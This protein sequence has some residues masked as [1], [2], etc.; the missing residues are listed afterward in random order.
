MRSDAP[1]A[2]AAPAG[3]E[4]LVQRLARAEA[5]IESLCREIVERYE[6][7]TLIHRLSDQL[8]ATLGEQARAQLVVEEASRALG[9][10][11]AE[12]WLMHDGELRLAASA[13]EPSPVAPAGVLREEGPLGALRHGRPWIREAGLGSEAAVAVPLGTPRAEAIGVLVLRGREDGRAFGTSEVKLLSAVT[14]LTAAFLRNDRLAEQARLTEDRRRHVALAREVHQTLRASREVDFPGLDV[15][16]GGGAPDTLGGDYY[17]HVLSP[18]GSL[19]LAL[20]SIAGDGVGAALCMAAAKGALE[21]EARAVGSPAEILRRTNETLAAEFTRTDAF[22][23]AFVARLAP[24][25]RALAYANGGHP[26]PLL[27]RA[28]GAVEELAEGGPVLGVFE[29]AAFLDDRVT[30]APGDIVALFT[31]ELRELASP[32]GQRFG[33]EGVLEALRSRP[34][35][36]ARELYEAVLAGAR[37]CRGA[38]ERPAHDPALVIVRAVAKT[39]AERA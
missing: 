13:P 36:S 31:S 20:A 34:D 12:M 39:R 7:V 32:A 22:A 37:A 3:T 26:A 2:G 6:E 10:R 8:G 11:H 5:E 16:Y 18:D 24:G 14:C 28:S 1:L 21:A 27:L 25:G 35:A 29:D 15:A 19:V 4:I 17:G 33:S 30:L 23:T 9:A 38:G